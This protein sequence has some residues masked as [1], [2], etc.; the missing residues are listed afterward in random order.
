MAGSSPGYQ[1]DVIREQADVEGH[2]SQSNDV[3]SDDSGRKQE[4][5]LNKSNAPAPESQPQ[6]PP[7]PKP[8]FVAG[9]LTKLGLDA[10][11][12]IAMFK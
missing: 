1:D 3:G 4:N 12:M 6:S 10:P 5:D 9:V 7:P 8:G 11:T 2:L